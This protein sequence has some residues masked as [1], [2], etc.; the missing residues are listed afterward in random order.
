MYIRMSFAD[1]TGTDI[2][3]YSLQC[4][5]RRAAQ[6]HSQYLAANVWRNDVFRDCRRIKNTLYIQ[7]RSK[8]TEYFTVFLNY[9]AEESDSPA[10]FLLF[11]Y[12]LMHYHIFLKK[13]TD[14]IARFLFFNS[15]CTLLF[16]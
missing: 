16:R 4:K 1:K 14:N 11:Y 9:G 2:V 5:P 6:F 13:S 3:G 12:F 15:G 10:P 8:L 7:H